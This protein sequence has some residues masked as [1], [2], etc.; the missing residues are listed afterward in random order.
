[1]TGL[2]GYLLSDFPDENG[3]N[4]ICFETIIPQ[5]R[6]LIQGFAILNSGEIPGGYKKFDRSKPV[7]K[8]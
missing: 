2:T 7:F 8:L 3:I 5:A 4:G 1:L 6:L